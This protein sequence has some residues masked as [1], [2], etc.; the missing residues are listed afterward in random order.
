MI[1]ITYMQKKS[2]AVNISDFLYKNFLG[3]QERALILFGNLATSIAK[4]ENFQES[5]MA[6]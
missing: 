3:C 1:S 4:L 6:L 2:S 5:S